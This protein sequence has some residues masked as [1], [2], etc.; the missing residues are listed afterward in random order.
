MSAI[1][2]TEVKS[3]LQITDTTYDDRI[4]Y[5]IPIVEST[6]FTRVLRRNFVDY[7]D[8]DQ[9]PEDV[10]EVLF[11]MINFHMNVGVSTVDQTQG[12]IQSIGDL[13][14]QTYNGENSIAGY[15]K[16]IIDSSLNRYK[17]MS[18]GYEPGVDEM[19][20]GYR[21]LT[22]IVLSGSING[23]NLEFTTTYTLQEN[24]EMIFV[25]QIKAT[26]DVDYTIDGSTIT[27]TTAPATGETL[28]F[29]GMVS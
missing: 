20:D 26:R 15:P 24:T 7:A 13:T 21:F 2:R 22:N 10:K 27:F 11:N 19:S 5:L 16:S 3:Y 28:T 6:L 29:G 8:A 14:Y 25:G 12:V 17:Q 4:D 18:R 1:L 23:V 9:T